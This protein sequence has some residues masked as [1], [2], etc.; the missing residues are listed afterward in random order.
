MKESA[1]QTIVMDYIKSVGGWCF[2]THGGSQFQRAGLP[3]VIACYK[4]FFFGL[5]LKVGNYQATELQK[6][7]LNN[8]QDT[9]GVGLVLRDNLTHIKDVIRYIDKYNKIP[10][11][12][13]YPVD[14]GIVFD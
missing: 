3:D 10:K 2:T 8:I 6:S 7:T 14:G 13:H 5:E 11:L 12:S 1:Y 9:G 4:G